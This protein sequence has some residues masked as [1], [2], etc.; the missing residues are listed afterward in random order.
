METFF[1]SIIA[2]CTDSGI[3]IVITIVLLIVGLK[4]AKWLVKFLE[5]H[6]S[7]VKLDEG[8]RRFFLNTI[9]IVLYGVVILSAAIYIGIP[10]ASFIT[11]LG[12]A[13]VAIGLALQG[14]LSNVASGILI[15]VNKPFKIGDFIEC[16]GVSGTVDDI[17]FFAVTLKT[18]DNK[19]V[20]CPN[21]SVTGGNI[22]NYSAMPTR[23]V[24][25]TFSVAYSS[26]IDTVKASIESVINAN[27]MI[28]KDPA[29]FIAATKYNESSIDF[30]VRVWVEAANYW[31][32]NFYMYNNVKAAFDKNGISIPY[33]TLDV[34]IKQ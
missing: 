31:D 21:S 4:V 29:P 23:R 22:I 12:S 17:G 1:N 25:F 8:I 2:F 13:G 19:T 20:T 16:A 6:K 15:L 34:N 7:F 28:L 11:V 27:D 14:S 9:K 3:K 24:D 5:N 32:V 10:A 30:V 18:P 33:P 26:D